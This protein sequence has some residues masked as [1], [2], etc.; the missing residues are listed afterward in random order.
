MI[1]KTIN[2][3]FY[4]KR[5]G[6]LKCVKATQGCKGCVG[7]SEFDSCD[8]FNYVCS[9]RDRDDKSDVVFVRCEDG[10]KTI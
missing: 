9:A 2:D 1:Q 4:D 10:R 6:W 3:V 8:L 7:S 5:K